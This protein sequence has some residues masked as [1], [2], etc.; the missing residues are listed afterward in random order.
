MWLYSWREYSGAFEGKRQEGSSYVMA[1]KILRLAFF[2]SFDGVF[3]VVLVMIW[4]GV[5]NIYVFG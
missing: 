4:S 5:K 3:V 1:G 2:G